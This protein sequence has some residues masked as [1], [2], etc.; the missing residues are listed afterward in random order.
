MDKKIKMTI[1]ETLK[2]E[3]RTAILNALQRGESFE[4]AVSVLINSGY[5]KDKISEV[6]NELMQEGIVKAVVP[7]SLKETLKQATK[8]KEELTTLK[9]LAE[10]QPRAPIIE[11]TKMEQPQQMKQLTQP[12][13]T[14]TASIT[15]Q[16]T[17]QPTPAVQAGVKA[18]QVKPQPKQEAITKTPQEKEKKAW[19]EEQQVIPQETTK[20]SEKATEMAKAKKEKETQKQKQAPKLMLIASA[21]SI[22]Y[23][24]VLVTRLKFRDNAW[25]FYLTQPLPLF[26]VFIILLVKK[27]INKVFGMIL[28][29]LSIVAFFYLPWLEVEGHTLL[30]KKIIKIFLFSKQLVFSGLLFILGSLLCFIL[31]ARGKEI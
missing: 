29:L 7:E 18:I 12:I 15:K 13:Q 8:A 25:V 19:P 4:Q 16:K 2:L 24:L 10:V 1:E 17:L 3:I 26:T 21:V 27:K 5:P 11:K 31:I 9:P 20:A 6:A 30:W 28:A 23:F 22:F 14:V